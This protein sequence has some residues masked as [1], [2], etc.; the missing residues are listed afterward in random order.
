[1]FS[2]QIEDLA[3]LVSAE[4]PSTLDGLGP[5]GGNAH[6]AGEWIDVTAMP[7]RTR[8]LAALEERV[9]GGAG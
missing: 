8:L 6:A 7:D 2:R 5:V 4:S 3:E 9:L 1:M